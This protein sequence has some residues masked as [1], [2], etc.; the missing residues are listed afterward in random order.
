LVA[1]FFVAA[2][3]P[4]FRENAPLQGYPQ[5]GGFRLL[6]RLQLVEA[7]NEEQ[8]GDLLHDAHRVRQAARPKVVPNGVDLILDLAHDH[9]VGTLW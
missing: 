7:L 9:D 1:H 3:V 8:V 5:R 2:P 4:P 6:E